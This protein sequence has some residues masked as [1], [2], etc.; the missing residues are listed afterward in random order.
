MCQ[1]DLVAEVELSGSEK[2][3]QIVIQKKIKDPDNVIDSKKFSMAKNCDCE[4][5]FN[6]TVTLMT[7]FNTFDFFSEGISLDSKT[8]IVKGVS[9]IEDCLQL[10]TTTESSES[11]TELSSITTTTTTSDEESAQTTEQTINSETTELIEN[12]DQTLNTDVIDLTHETQLTTTTSTPTTTTEWIPLRNDSENE[13]QVSPEEDENIENGL[14][15]RRGIGNGDMPNTNQMP[16]Y[17]PN[18]GA[19]GQPYPQYT[20]SVILAIYPFRDPMEAIRP[21]H[22]IQVNDITHRNNLNKLLTL[23]T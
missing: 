12:T 14:I 10:T 22:C 2:C 18:S 20:L 21:L 4:D 3:G 13:V 1:F 17:I 5:Q 8:V 19:F 15:G 7:S 23:I 11:S 6:T 16:V 9:P